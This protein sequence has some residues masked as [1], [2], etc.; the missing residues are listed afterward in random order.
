MSLNWNI[1][2]VTSKDDFEDHLHR[3]DE[4]GSGSAKGGRLR[5]RPDFLS[6]RLCQ[7][8]RHQ[9]IELGLKVGSDGYV[10]VNELI[11][12]SENKNAPLYGF[13]L[14]DLVKTVDQ[15]KKKRFDLAGADGNWRIRATQG[16]SM[17]TIDDEELCEPVTAARALLDRGEVCVHGTTRKAWKKIR[18]E[19]LKPMGR[20]HIHFASVAS[21]VPKDCCD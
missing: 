9:A 18:Q 12:Y 6:R 16:H 10:R 7:I 19:G 3:V 14:S 13:S 1:I 8:L 15:D 21:L 11:D 20:N 4:E 2:K 5:D 17:K